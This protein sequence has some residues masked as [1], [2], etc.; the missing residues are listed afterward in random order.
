M[1]SAIRLFSPDEQPPEPVPEHCLRRAVLAYVDHL[2][3]KVSAG[4]FSRDHFSNVRRECMRYAAAWSV[5]LGDRR[6]LLV[7]ETEPPRPARRL[8]EY[9]AAKETDAIAVAI[10]LAAE[11]G[12]APATQ[13]AAGAGAGRNGDRAIQELT[14]DDLTRWVLANP[15][16]KSG[17]AK[18]N[19][20]VF[21]HGCLKWYEDETGVKNPYK[22]GRMPSFEKG[23][24]RE[25]TDAEY[26]ALM[27]HTSCRELRRV[28]WSLYNLDGIRP[29][30][31]RQMLW[32]EFNWEAEFYFRKKHKTSRK[33]KKGRFWALTPRRHR[34]FANLLRQRP[35]K[36]ESEK[37]CRC[38]RPRAPGDPEHLPSDHV[39]LNT[40]GTPWS[41]RALSLNLRRVAK[42]IGLDDDVAQVVSCYCF[43]H[44]F[45]TQADEAGLL[46]QD[47]AMLL[48][49]NDPKMLR[50]VYSKKSRKIR[51]LRG[52]AM[53]AERLR[54][55][56]RHA[57]RKPPAPRQEPTPLFDAM[58]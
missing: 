43:R 27:R 1:P 13:D 17:H 9:H 33:T 18:T 26:L 4:T 46:D 38:D 54:R 28:L 48:G 8:L 29:G 5:T 6:H 52:A 39:F 47:T 3:L 7:P 12:L 20:L 58:E 57:E 23:D 44:T 2:A 40:D 24:R 11:L 51:N 50:E 30:E 35:P 25:A 21:I 55:E 19:P 42:R 32:T 16:W 41:R 49:H 15:Q 31:A 37:P 36:P 34:F 14:N 53:K 10:R 22:R 45:A 56:M